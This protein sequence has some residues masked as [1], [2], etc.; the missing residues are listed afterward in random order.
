MPT[1]EPLLAETAQYAYTSWLL[2]LVMC[3]LA[4]AMAGIF[5]CIWCLDPE[6]IEIKVVVTFHIISMILNR[7][8]WVCAGF[9]IGSRLSILKQL[10]E[11]RTA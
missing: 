4:T 3:G 1:N 2:F 5:S 8:Y 6:S 11:Y 9:I 10:T 7:L